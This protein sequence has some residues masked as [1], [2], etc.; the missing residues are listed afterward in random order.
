MAEPRCRDPHDLAAAAGHGS[1]PPAA[2]WEGLPCPDAAESPHGGGS[3]FFHAKTPTIPPLTG[4]WVNK[5]EQQ[6]RH[7]FL[8][9]LASS[10]ISVGKT[11]CACRWDEETDWTR[12]AA[13]RVREIP[14]R[15]RRASPQSPFRKGSTPLWRG[16]G[17]CR[18]G[19][20]CDPRRCCPRPNLPFV[21][22]V[23]AQPGR[24]FAERGIP[25]ALS[26]QAGYGHVLF[27]AGRVSHVERGFGCAPAALRFFNGIF[28]IIYFFPPT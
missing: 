2:G 13:A 10:G 23:P 1:V 8:F 4:L 24:D 17:F 15:P 21:K 20:G 28:S 6:A 19:D 22:G 18:K 14:R 3:H 9:F 11:H 26:C 25:D 16:E 7:W 5:I 12:S 27:S